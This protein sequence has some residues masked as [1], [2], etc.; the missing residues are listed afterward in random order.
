M[1][2]SRGPAPRGMTL[3]ELMVAV[4]VVGIIA[5]LSV[6]GFQQLTTNSRESTAVREVYG[7][8]MQARSIARS[9]AEPVRFELTEVEVDGRTFNQVRW[10]R[11]PCSDT[12]GTNC[13]DSACDGSA[14]GVSGCVCTQQGEP[15]NV[16]TSVAII[17]IDGLCFIGGTGVPRI[18]NSGDCV[19]LITNAPAANAVTLTPSHGG[20]QRMEIEPLTG[21]VRMVDCGST[22]CT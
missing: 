1:K 7:Q 13:P 4:A 15:I 22:V 10:S 17:G 14:C 9:G 2:I 18:R 21:M 11:L 16:P 3:I 20:V 5:A 6:T 19:D 12:W 8:L